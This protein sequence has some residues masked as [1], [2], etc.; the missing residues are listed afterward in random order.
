MEFKKIE[1]KPNI[2]QDQKLMDK[3]DGFEKLINELEKKEVPPDIVNSI[4]RDIDEINSFSGSGKDLLKQFRKTQSGIIKMLEKELKL[5]TKNHYR[6]MWLAVG[7]S[8]FGIPIGVIIW[9]IADN[10]GLLAIGIPI[11]MGIGIAVGIAMDKKANE[12]GKQLDVEIK[13]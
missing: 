9:V 2:D 12:N 3:F 10:P 7:M 6:N 4:N 11:G 8:A 5:V 13:Y 1:K